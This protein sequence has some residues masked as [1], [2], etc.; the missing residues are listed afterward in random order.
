MKVPIATLLS[1]TDL[2]VKAIVLSLEIVPAK[3]DAGQ[4][5]KLKE[6]IDAMTSAAKSIGSSAADR[7]NIKRA[8]DELAKHDNVRS[9]LCV[10]SQ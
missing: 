10:M 3:F 8:Q 5:A 6:T 7:D 4:I 2:V 1:D 9:R